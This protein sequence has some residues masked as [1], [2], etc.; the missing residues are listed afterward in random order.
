MRILVAVSTGGSNYDAPVDTDQGARR[1]RHP[2]PAKSSRQLSI[3]GDAATSKARKAA[4][5]K[6]AQH[7]LAQPEQCGADS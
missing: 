7:A 6:T 1:R 2:D 5:A 4:P 3:G